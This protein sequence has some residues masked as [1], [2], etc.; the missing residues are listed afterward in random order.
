MGLSGKNV[1]VV[2]ATSGIG[3]ATARRL[4]G[5]GARV[6]FAGRRQA[7]GDALA[8][9]LGD[10]AGFQRAD[11]TVESDVEALFAAAA[12]HGPIDGAVNCAGVPLPG[13]PVTETDVAQF[14]EYVG[15]LAAGA[16]SFTKHAGLHMVPAKRGSIVH[17]S[18]TS[19]HLGGWSGIAYS[20]GKAALL[21][22]VRSAAVE[23]GEQGV[24]VN[25]VCPGPILTG[26]FAKAAGVDPS[27]A[28]VME[29]PEEVF[30][31]LVSQWQPIPGAGYPDDVAGAILWLLDDSARFVNGVDV[32][33][34]GG[35]LAG[36]PASVGMPAR[37]AMAAA[38]K[39]REDPSNV[40]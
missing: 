11:V 6:T 21:Q 37:A 28:D 33:V 1:V 8:A 24:R 9:E 27:E 26:M 34:D 16:V 22:V 10:G 7:E 17:L 35:I 25:S 18:S 12:E 20:A 2:G 3:A 14:A 32:P 40:D 30:A 38:F 19:G 39:R 29:A 23:L 4:V 31:E 15:W 13:T 5:E 36:R